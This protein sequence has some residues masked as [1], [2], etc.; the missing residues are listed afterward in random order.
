MAEVW[1]YCVREDWISVDAH[2]HWMCVLKVYE[3]LCKI[4]PEL[5]ILDNQSAVFYDAASYVKFVDESY[6]RK[7]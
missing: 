6:A 4:E 7:T 2:A 1:T 5:L 3:L